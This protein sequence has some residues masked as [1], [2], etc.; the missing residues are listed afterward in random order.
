MIPILVGLLAVIAI[1]CA[2]TGRWGF[3]IGT[4]LGAAFCVFVLNPLL[5]RHDR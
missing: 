2:I 1:L 3:L 5:E 4:L